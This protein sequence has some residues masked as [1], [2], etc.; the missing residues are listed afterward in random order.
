MENSEKIEADTHQEYLLKLLRLEVEHREIAR[1]DRLIKSAGFYNQKSFD[2]FRFDEVTLPS[3]I[4]PQY[5]KDCEFLLEKKNLVFYGNI[6]AG[7]TH[8]A[9]AL[10]LEACRMGKP[11]RF[12]RTAALVNRLSEAKKNKDLSVLMKHIL[13]A[14]LLIF[15]EWGYVPLDRDG[16]QL[17]FE[18]VSECYERKSVII[19][20]N[21]EFSRWVN[22]LYDEQMTGALLDRLLHHCYLLLFE[23]SSERMKTSLIQKG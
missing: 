21:I 8:L 3:S 2:A 4:S 5:L 17:L 9:T 10:G 6:G 19:T 13:K 16:A 1:R 7:K 15:D 11:V 20:T 12:F 18:I 23:G 22:V 14:D